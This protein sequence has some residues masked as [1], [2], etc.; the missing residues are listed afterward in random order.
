[1]IICRV[2]LIVSALAEVV[3]AQNLDVA[4]IA[5]ANWGVT[6]CEMTDP[7]A[8]ILGTGLFNSVDLIS[9]WGATPTL[10]QLLIYDSV[11]CWTNILPDD[12]DAWGDV[13]ADYV[14]AGGGVVVTVFGNSWYKLGGRWAT[15]GYEL[16]AGGIGWTT[17][18]ANLGI[19]HDPHHPV[20]SGVDTFNGGPGSFRPTTTL[21]ANGVTLVA[22]WSDGKVLVAEGANPSRIDLGMF[23]AS[24]ACHWYFWR[25]DSDGDLLMA[26]SLAY[27]ARGGVG[28]G[29]PYCFGDPG[30][31]TPCPCAN[32]ND[33]SLAGAGCHNGVSR[34][35]ARLVG[36]GQASVAG[37]TLVLKTHGL[38]PNR[39]CLYFQAD[40]RING[41]DGRALSN[42]L[43]CAG[44]AL[45]RLQIRSSDASGF[46]K[47]S[48]GLAAAGSVSA[49]QTK[50]YQCCYLTSTNPPCGPAQR[51]NLSNGYEVAWTP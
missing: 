7:R 40:N 38:E 21:L 41:G 29:T 34:S 11:M 46:S 31:G 18:Q 47:T 17:G 30:S 36:R 48:I 51:F 8:K 2:L 13:M 4:L 50:R 12:R 16:F 44:G 24:S 19:V 39:P 43:R 28:P 42:G 35:G 25:Q 3:P 15:G 33:G 45:V 37:D 49:G 26:N 27:T 23:P 6:G 10:D 9:T 32:D 22:E 5:S 20:M 1:M 14:D